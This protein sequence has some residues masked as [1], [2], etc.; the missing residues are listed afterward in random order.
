[1]TKQLN[2]EGLEALKPCP[3][4]GS[5]VELQSSKTLGDRLY[6]IACKG[7]SPCF[8]SGLGVYLTQSQLPMALSAW[9]R[10]TPTVD[11]PRVEVEPAAWLTPYFENNV[12]GKLVPIIVPVQSV[13]PPADDWQPLY[14]ACAI[15][16]AFNQGYAAR[17][18]VVDACRLRAETAEAS[19]AT[20]TARAER[21][22]AA[23]REID[24]ALPKPALPFVVQ[25]RRKDEGIFW[26]DM[27]AFDV[28]GV[29]ERYRD[30]CAEG[31]VPW[32]Y[33]IVDRRTLTKEN[34]NGR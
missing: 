18:D 28:P 1:M 29:A 3:F 20:L 25:Y 22:E 8:G 27:A 15:E 9:N 24:E 10:R 23:L 6:V 26:V 11:L 12:K 13:A 17:D 14:P 5:D 2:P 33:Q 34:D 7:D 16:A 31:D 32:E 19:V 4:C 21:A 30:K